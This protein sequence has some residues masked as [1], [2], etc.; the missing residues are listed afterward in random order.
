MVEFLLGTSLSQAFLFLLGFCY[1]LIALGVAILIV[2]MVVKVTISI[3]GQIWYTINPKS[4]T[5]FVKWYSYN[6][7]KRKAK[8]AEKANKGE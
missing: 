1:N 6:K 8:K 7:E 3:L 4:H 2:Y 5:A